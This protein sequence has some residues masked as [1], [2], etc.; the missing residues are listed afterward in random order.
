MS[1]SQ[2]KKTIK[3]D[4]CDN[5]YASR[6]HLKIHIRAIHEKAVMEGRLLRELHA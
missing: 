3:C 2:E 4:V 6:Q 5:T 1:D